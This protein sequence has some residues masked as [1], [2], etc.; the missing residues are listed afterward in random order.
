L[1]LYLEKVALITLSSQRGW[2]E[3]AYVDAF[4]GPWRAS[5]ERFEDTSVSIALTQLAR[6]QRKLQ[7]LN[8]T[9]ELRALFVE[10]DATAFRNLQRILLTE[11]PV[12]AQSLN[13][14]FMNYV[15]EAAAFIGDN[16]FSLTFI[17]P[18]GWS[19]DLQ[20]LAPLLRKRGEVLVNF[21]YNDI[22]RHLENPLA[23]AGLDAFFGGPGWLNEIW[24]L[25]DQGRTREDA[26]LGAYAN[27]LKAI[28]RFPFVTYT[29]IKWPDQERTY[30]Y[31][32]YAT[33]HW[34]GLDAFRDVEERAVD[35]QEQVRLEAWLKRRETRTGS[36]DLFGAETESSGLA[37]LRSRSR[38]MIEEASRRIVR[39]LET[40]ASFPVSSAYEQALE[41]P[42]VTVT[43]VHDVLKQAV[44]RKQAAWAIDPGR[45]KPKPTDMLRSLMFR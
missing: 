22:N 20:A 38:I 40:S 35:I 4:S 44:M 19:I 34:R 14:D 29:R 37:D 43:D 1:N 9:C 33:R 3:F 10:K 31:L 30:F 42:L 36:G 12:R 27:R 7:E 5:S 13:G 17:D 18:T 39:M 16:A 24:A 11:S 45:R 2:K 6:V 28:G 23:Q 41:L 32:V 21:M 15:G 26:L 8:R 25:I